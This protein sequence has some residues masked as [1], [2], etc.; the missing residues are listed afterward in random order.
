MRFFRIHRCA[1]R[2]MYHWFNFS[3][4]LR[5]I[6]FFVYARILQRNVPASEQLKS[7][8][9]GCTNEIARFAQ[10]YFFLRNSDN[11]LSP[12]DN[13]I[14]LRIFSFA[15]LIW[16]IMRLN[17]RLKSLI[18]HGNPLSLRSIFSSFRFETCLYTIIR[19]WYIRNIRSC[20]LSLVIRTTN[21]RWSTNIVRWNIIF[22]RYTIWFFKLYKFIYSI[23]SKIVNYFIC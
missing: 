18:I 23:L 9:K 14:F 5:F 4:I 3:R 22:L 7:L 2:K 8:T 16:S 21:E 10:F 17:Q 20:N 15:K 12:L 13:Q 6:L 1:Q 11:R 19:S